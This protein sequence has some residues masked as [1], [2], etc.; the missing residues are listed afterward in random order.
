MQE[1]PPAARDR[2]LSGIEE[3]EEEE[4]EGG[5]GGDETVVI[6][7]RQKKKKNFPVCRG[8]FKKQRKVSRIIN[9]ATLG[10]S[11]STPAA[12]AFPPYAPS[13]LVRY[14]ILAEFD[15]D[16]GSV[17]K[18]QYPGSCAEDQLLA[19]TMLPDGAHNHEQDWTVFFLNRQGEDRDR[20][21]EKEK[22]KERG[23]AGSGGAA[24]SS[25]SSARAGKDDKPNKLVSGKAVMG[26]VY[27]FDAESGSWVPTVPDAQPLLLTMT[28]LERPARDATADNPCKRQL[29][30]T[31]SGAVVMTIPLHA[32]M[33]HTVLRPL[34]SSIYTRDGR[35]LGFLFDNDIEE[36]DF[37]SQFGQGIASLSKEAEDYASAKAREDDEARKKA[38]AL[39]LE[40]QMLQRDAAAATVA[41]T[42][43]AAPPFL[44]CLNLVMTKKDA[45]VRR[46]AVVKAL[47]ICTEAQ[48]IQVLKPIILLALEEYYAR[49][50]ID[51]LAELYRSL[52][53]LDMSSIAGLS[54]NERAA[55]RHAPPDMFATEYATHCLWQG[56]KI[57]IKV[58]TTLHEDDVGEPSLVVLLKKF[59]EHTMTLF[60]ACLAEK[61]VLFLGY[62]HKAGEVCKFALSAAL[63]VAPTIRGI[64]KQRVF[65][66]CNLVNLKFLEVPG[67]I[68]GVTNPLFESRQG[69]WDVCADIETG[70]VT[71]NPNTMPARPK[72]EPHSDLDAE[73]YN[74]VMAGVS[75]FYSSQWVCDAFEEYTRSIVEQAFDEEVYADEPARAAQTAANSARVARFKTSRAFVELKAAREAAR[76]AHG[77]TYVNLGQKIRLLRIAKTLAL[78]DF[79]A[80]IADVKRYIRSQDQFYELLACMPQSKSGIQA[81]L[82]GIFASDEMARRATLSLLMHIA[83][84]THGPR[85]FETLNLFT[86]M[87]YER[88]VN[89]LM[90]EAGGEGGGGGGGAGALSS[91]GV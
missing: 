66:Y 55:R 10:P 83:S 81:L 7:L 62:Q 45:S 40:R 25:S 28:W 69:W 43:P 42:D 58:P 4:G 18:Y 68:A 11:S 60:N 78:D 79:L 24:A 85:L 86:F 84:F 72:D 77:Y 34:F 57:P 13:L 32:G 49:P 89:A 53:A 80:L 6:R 88:S 39:E 23:G 61:R 52:N 87:A 5:G 74:M 73:F 14:I 16:K 1:I 51:V 46:G 8:C 17:V 2:T 54:P 75:S 29:L 63:L 31:Q 44:Y 71:R 27:S 38:A 33:Q 64:V 35:A 19:E 21:R 50:S 65:P 47:A 90:A 76:L 20:D 70:V 3:R 12:P 15:I 67:F 56:I 82:L 9:P 41:L 37:F 22:E 59:K 48:F 91:R 26:S 36:A 30:V